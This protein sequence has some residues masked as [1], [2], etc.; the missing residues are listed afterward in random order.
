[1]NWDIHVKEIS[2]CNAWRILDELKGEI[3][4]H[5][6]MH[7]DLIMNEKSYAETMESSYIW[8]LV[9]WAMQEGYWMDSEWM[10]YTY[11]CAS[12]LSSMIESN[13]IKMNPMWWT[14]CDLYGV[15]WRISEVFMLR[16]MGWAMMDHDLE[17]M[18]KEKNSTYGLKIGS[19]WAMD[20]YVLKQVIHVKISLCLSRYCDGAWRRTNADKYGIH[21]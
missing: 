1:M 9:P 7:W 8:R 10:P 19:W 15:H 3:H 16:L 20:D 6:Y 18:I 2:I 12:R 13:M 4:Q 14:R 11:S 5:K 17:R 21:G